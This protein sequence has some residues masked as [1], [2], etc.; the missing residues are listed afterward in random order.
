MECLYKR[1]SSACFHLDC[2]NSPPNG[3]LCL[4]FAFLNPS[5][6]AL[7]EIYPN[8]TLL[9]FQVPRFLPDKIWPF[10][11]QKKISHHLTLIRPSCHFLPWSP[12]VVLDST[13]Q[14]L[15]DSQEDRF[16]HSL[17]SLLLPRSHFPHSMPKMPYASFATVSGSL[18]PHSSVS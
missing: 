1:P 2:D 10:S 3:S 15:W 8:W 4:G 14:L 16:L 6:Y 18:S 13:T 9:P 17:T 5:Q 7:R 11:I 12:P